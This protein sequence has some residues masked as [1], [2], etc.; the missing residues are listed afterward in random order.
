MQY[1]KTGYYTVSIKNHTF[2]NH[3]NGEDYSEIIKNFDVFGQLDLNSEEDVVLLDVT[4]PSLMAVFVKAPYDMKKNSG[5]I[6]AYE[7]IDYSRISDYKS[8][9]ELSEEETVENFLNKGE[10]NI[11]FKEAK[12]I[13]SMIYKIYKKV[14]KED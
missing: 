6:F 9:G 12:A 4:N 2:I 1:L 3:A 8:P 10:A 11:G 14:I 5:Y 7:A 13:V